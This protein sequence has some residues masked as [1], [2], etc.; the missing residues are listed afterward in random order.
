MNEEKERNLL[1][2]KLPK[3]HHELDTLL[4]IFEVEFLVQKNLYTVSHKK[5]ATLF[6]IIPSVFIGRFLY[7]LYQ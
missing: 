5:R 6:L 3:V 4:W 2:K 7:F 1:M